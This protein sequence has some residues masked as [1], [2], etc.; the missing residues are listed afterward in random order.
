MGPG[1]GLDAKRSERDA[2]VTINLNREPP[3]LFVFA[4]AHD[5]G[6]P[7]DPQ[8]LWL[9]QTE[10]EDTVRE[11]I[12]LRRGAR[13]HVWDWRHDGIRHRCAKLLNKQ[14]VW[15]DPTHWLAKAKVCV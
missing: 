2:E 12:L 7:K 3:I 10:L 4:A 1:G 9:K 6:V 14:V 13:L 8:F 5:R 11:L 15:S